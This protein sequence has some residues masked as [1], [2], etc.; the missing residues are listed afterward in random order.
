MR[1]VPEVT[2][3]FQFPPWR[4]GPGYRGT[5]FRFVNCSLKS[6]DEL[7]EELGNRKAYLGESGGQRP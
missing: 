4:T 1:R 2:E 5:G 3:C 6:S 7:C